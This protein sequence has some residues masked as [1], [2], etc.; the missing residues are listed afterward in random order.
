M[1]SWLLL[2]VVVLLALM[3]TPWWWPAAI[4][5]GIWK[6]FQWH[7]YKGRPWKRIHFPM[8]RNYAA[9]LGFESA[10]AKENS[11]DLDYNRAVKN[12]VLTA[13]PGISD[14]MA[15]TF[16]ENERRRCAD[17]EDKILL[18]EFLKSKHADKPRE[19]LE[20]Y[21]TEAKE[22]FDPS[23]PWLMVRMVIAGLIELQFG[24]QHRAEYLYAV[25][26]GKAA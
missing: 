21:I 1:I 18:L 17:F 7:F 8:M 11:R 10:E 4:L 16:V 9:V 22:K 19:I 5:I 14:E 13:L 24:P 26:T 23:S 3:V 6:A 25:L 20:Q 12:L 2:V 15:F